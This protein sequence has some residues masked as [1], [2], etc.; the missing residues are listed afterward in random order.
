MIFAENDNPRVKVSNNA[1]MPMEPMRHLEFDFRKADSYSGD[2]NTDL[3]RFQIALNEIERICPHYDRAVPLEIPTL[4]N[5]DI[6]SGELTIE[7]KRVRTDKGYVDRKSHEAGDGLMTQLDNI[8]RFNE[9]DHDL[10]LSANIEGR[11]GKSVIHAAVHLKRLDLVKKL[12]SQGAKVVSIGESEVESPLTQA[13]HMRDRATEKLRKL[14]A[15]GG[16]PNAIAAQAA[17]RDDFAAIV[18][19]LKEMSGDNR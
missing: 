8:S 14:E 5:S 10:K 15:S 18:V 2:K 19:S 7:I 11:N 12:G 3:C 1:R 16:D 6:K 17:L 4:A 13:Q 9:A